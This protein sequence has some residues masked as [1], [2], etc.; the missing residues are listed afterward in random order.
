M[1]K[2][3]DRRYGTAG[4]LAQ[5]LKQYLGGG[6]ITARRAGLPRRA[7]KSVRRHPAAT[8]VSVGV[9]ALALLGTFAQRIWV[10]RSEETVGRLVA[11]A[12]V[13][14]RE[15]TYRQGLEKIDRA[16]ALAPDSPEVVRTRG[17]LLFEANTDPREMVRVARNIVADN[18]DDW[19]AHGWLAFAGVQGLGDIDVD[20]HVAALE[21]AAPDIA[22]AWY[23]RALAA[24]SE[25]EKLAHLDRVLELQPGHALALNG[26]SQA[27]RRLHDTAGAIADARAAIAARPRST[28][29]RRFLAAIYTGLKDF[30]PRV[31]KTWH[32]T[33]SC[34]VC[35]PRVSPRS[36]SLPHL[37]CCWEWTG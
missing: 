11:A 13:D 6:L 26:R 10:S 24:R 36:S 27:K 28:R 31:S 29:G 23:I 33:G 1:E 9:I 16:L 22:E 5:D 20:A 17:R 32:S 19:E 34:R 15:G 35:C 12:E 21:R 30:E 2:D 4:E 25:V 3:P 18:P 7:W 14:L 8:A 37:Y